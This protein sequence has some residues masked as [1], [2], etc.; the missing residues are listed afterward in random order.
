MTEKQFSN[1]KTKKFINY[2][3]PVFK[4]RITWD[5]AR[6]FWGWHFLFYVWKSSMHLYLCFWEDCV[7]F[8]SVWYQDLTFFIKFR[9]LGPRR[10]FIWSP[11]FQGQPFLSWQNLRRKFMLSPVF[12]GQPFLSW[13]NL[14]RNFIW[15]PVFQ[16]QPFLSWQN[17]RRNFFPRIIRSG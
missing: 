11:V 10:K 7:K 16:G 12:Q 8:I 17:L 14:R 2:H 4:W 6:I 9:N 15:S 5:Y 3:I 13:Q 1:L